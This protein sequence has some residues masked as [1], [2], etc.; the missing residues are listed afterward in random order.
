MFARYPDTALLAVERVE[1]IEMS[2]DDITQLDALKCR[3]LNS[4]V[5]MGVDSAKDPW[6]AVARATD[7]YSVGAGEIKYLARFLR[8]IDVAIGEYRDA[9]V[10]LD[11][12]YGVVLRRAVVEVRARAA[13]DGE[14][15][16]AA[17][18]GDAR[19]V[20]AVAVLPV[21]AGADLERHR[22]IDRT[23]HGIEDA[24]HEGCV[25]EQRRTA[26]AA[27]DLFRRTSHVQ[28][29]D[30]GTECHVGARGLR[31]RTR[32]GTGE[33]HDARC[34]LALVIHAMARLGRV[35]Q[36]LVGADHL[37]GRQSGA[38]PAAENAERPIGYA[39]HRREHHAR[40]E[41]VAADPQRPLSLNA[42]RDHL[43]R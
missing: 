7:H 3:C 28:I 12:A 41:C 19:D 25:A 26:R 33:L 37:G 39:R 15:R 21:P 9:N 14:R 23:H 34:G 38:E 8:R 29:D 13:V 16:N 20:D 30:V 32:V 1:G 18:F 24:R 2:E 31:Q 40:G 35:P 11:V 17:A 42:W 43:R 22:H 10:R 27:T 5:Q 4:A 6:R 36:P